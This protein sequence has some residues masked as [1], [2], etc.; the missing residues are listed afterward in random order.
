MNEE[1]KW[2]WGARVGESLGGGSAKVEVGSGDEE[3]EGS[4]LEEQ[5]R[6]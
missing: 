3:R 6:K 4:G 5:C 2:E 1:W